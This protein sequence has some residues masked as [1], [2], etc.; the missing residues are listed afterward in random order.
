MWTNINTTP[1]ASVLQITAVRTGIL[2]Y[3]DAGSP[4]KHGDQMTTFISA[5]FQSE[6]FRKRHYAA[7]Q[8]KH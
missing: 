5:L 8:L 2:V 4:N 7:S 3:G 1:S 6:L